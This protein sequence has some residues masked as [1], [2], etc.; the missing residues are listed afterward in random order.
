MR[1]LKQLLKSVAIV[2]MATFVACDDKTSEKQEDNIPT[3]P[4]EEMCYTPAKTRFEVW[5]PTAESAIVR[6]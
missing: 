6:L 4:I 2:A 1:H 3:K 5:A